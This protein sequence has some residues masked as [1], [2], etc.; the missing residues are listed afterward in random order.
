MSK[1]ITTLTPTLQ[2]VWAEIKPW[3]EA[4]FPDRTLWIGSAQRTPV[5]QLHLFCQGR[6]PECQGPVVT[7]KDGFV[8]TSKHNIMPLAKAMDIWIKVNG[9]YN[10]DIQLAEPFAQFV[11]EKYSG[12]LRW[13]GAFN[14]SYHLEEI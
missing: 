3:Y 14:D 12:I 11:R 1:D 4:Q 7:W 2:K 5:E 9:V 6:L 10:W 8:C 13:G